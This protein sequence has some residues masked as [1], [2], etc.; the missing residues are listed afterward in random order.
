MRKSKGEESTHP[1]HLYNDSQIT[2]TG[3][4]KREWMVGQVLNGM[5]SNT[6]IDVLAGDPHEIA[7]LALKIAKAALG[8]LRETE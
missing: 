5:C 3:L 6:D 1:Y 4:T 7:K 8:L 2:E